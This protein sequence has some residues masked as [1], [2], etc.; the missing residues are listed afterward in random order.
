MTSFMIDV[1]ER[2]IDL[3]HLLQLILQCLRAVKRKIESRSSAELGISIENLYS[4]IVSYP[5]RSLSTHD[6]IDFDDVSR[7]IVIHDAS[8]DRFDLLSKSHRFVDD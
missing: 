6:Q 7:S 3:R 1:N 8:I 2:S 5:Q 4:H